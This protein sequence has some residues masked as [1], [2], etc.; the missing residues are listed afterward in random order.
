MQAPVGGRRRAAQ[1]ERPG[2]FKPISDFVSRQ[3]RSKFIDLI[4]LPF[5]I[6][7]GMAERFFKPR[8]YRAIGMFSTMHEVKLNKEVIATATCPIRELFNQ[9]SLLPA[10]NNPAKLASFARSSFNI[11]G[12][13][14]ESIKLVA[15]DRLNGFI[16]QDLFFTRAARYVLGTDL[17]STQAKVIRVVLMAVQAVFFAHMMNLAMNVPADMHLPLLVDEI[18]RRVL[19]DSVQETHGIMASF[20]PS[21]AYEMGSLAHF[22]WKNWGCPVG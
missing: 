13:F 11:V 2:F 16:L 10:E 8:T 19:R 4:G 6:G 22:V 20:L 9:I 21:F 1:A 3:G 5:A 15:L 14:K 12:M 18:V 7:A 17:N